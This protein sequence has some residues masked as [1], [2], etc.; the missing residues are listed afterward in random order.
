MVGVAVLFGAALGSFGN[1]VIY[2]VPLGMSV[3]SPP[4]ACPQC[5]HRI[6]ARHNVPVLGWLVLRGRCAHCSTRISPRYPIVEA[7][8]GVLFGLVVVAYGLSWTTLLLLIAA[9]AAVV[10]AAIDIDVQRL[11]VVVVWPWGLA[12]AVVVLASAATSGQWDPALRALIGSA[13]LW[14]FYGL[15]HLLY[16]RGMGRGDVR[17]AGVIG[18][19]LGFMGWGPLVVGGFAAF[20]WG[21]VGAIMPM[22]RARSVSGVRIPFGPWMLLGAATGIVIGA[23]VASWYTQ[24]VLGL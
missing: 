1:V 21:L 7:T 14:A 24:Q 17:L 11:P 4:S 10:L 16:R 13:A 12:T 22:I 15:A 3:V 23:P 20:V 19:V 2:R 18:G 8:V 9:W 5:H 6:A